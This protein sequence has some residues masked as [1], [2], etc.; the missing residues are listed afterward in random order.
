MNDAP[1]LKQAEVGVAMGIRGT[2]VIFF[3]FERLTEPDDFSRYAD[4]F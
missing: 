1:A 4:L 3:E 2:E